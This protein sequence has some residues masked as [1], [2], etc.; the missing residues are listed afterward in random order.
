M[1]IKPDNYL[2]NTLSE[3]VIAEI[4]QLIAAKLE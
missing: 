2:L 3:Q 4:A 1:S